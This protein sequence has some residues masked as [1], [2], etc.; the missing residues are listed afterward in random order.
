MIEPLSV[1]THGKLL[2]TAHDLGLLPGSSVKLD[3]LKL[4]GFL[5]FLSSFLPFFF[6][7]LCVYIILSFLSLS[8]FSGARSLS[9]GQGSNSSPSLTGCVTFSSSHLCGK[10]IKMPTSEPCCPHVEALSLRSA[11]R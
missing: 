4:Y 7:F 8:S 2:T 9:K 3:I 5:P 10:E 11:S 6:F 1:H